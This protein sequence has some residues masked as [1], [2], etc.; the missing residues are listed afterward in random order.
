MGNSKI[1]LYSTKTNSIVNTFE[2]PMHEKLPVTAVAF[3]PDNNEFK[4]HNILAAACK[5]V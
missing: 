3:R 5:T 1:R 4:T 2:T